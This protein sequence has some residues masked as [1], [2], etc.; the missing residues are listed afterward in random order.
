MMVAVAAA[1]FA[2]RWR[3]RTVLKR[4]PEKIGLNIQQSATGFT[5]SKSDQGHTLFKVQASKAVQFK[6]GGRTEL[7]DVEITVY[8][9]DSSRFDRIFGQDFVYE[10][11]SGN[12]SAE[13]EVRI[14][15][16]ANPEGVLNPD[17]SQPRELKNP[18]HLQTSGLV[19][20][21]KT[22]DAYTKEKIE[23][24][25]EN[26]RGS[27]MGASYT[28]KNSVLT[29]QSEINIALSGFASDL[30]PASITASHGTIEKDPALVSLEHPQL[31]YGAKLARAGDA[32]LFLRPNSKIDRVL[33]KGD[34]ILQ[35]TGE[36]PMSARANQME[37]F[38]SP[39]GAELRNAV[40]SGDVHIET[41]GNQAIRVD[42][43]QVNG[44]FA[45]GN[46]L[47]KIRAEKLVKMIQTHD[48]RSNPS[49]DAQDFELRASGM[50]FFLADGRRLQR[51]ETSGAAEAII[52]SKN[53]DAATE[54][55]LISA[56]KFRAQFDGSGQL[57][58]IHGAPD[59]RITSKSDKDKK[60]SADR[61][62][63]SD[64][65]DLI[66]EQSN[67]ISSISQSGHFVY[68]EGDRKVV[69]ER[70][71]YTPADR[72]IAL[73]GSPRMTDKG[74]SVV[75][76]GMQMDFAIGNAVAEG[77]VKTTY[78][79]LKPMQQGALLASSDPIHVTADTMTAT[80]SPS[81]ANYQ[82]NA[83]LW[84][85]TDVISAP[86]I[87]FDQDRRSVLARSPGIGQ[88]SISLLQAGKAS[89]PELVTIT[90][91]SFSYV[92]QERKAHLEGP[93]LVTQSNATIAADQMEIFLQPNGQASTSG[94]APGTGKVE[95]IVGQGNILITQTG[96]KATGD[97]LVYTASD[98]KFVLSGKSP[99]IFDATH[100]RITGVSL[101]LFGRDGRVLVEGSDKSPALTQSQVAR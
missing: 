84:Q 100:G 77:Q 85:G 78:T 70:A 69:A 41:A 56:G 8:G 94:T 80:R 39:E 96:R 31:R 97:Q 49:G 25:V 50:D 61:V 21:Q 55:T 58:T 12:I 32:V 81:K 35:S 16:E 86:S 71:T 33:A 36:Q 43:G 68:T 34:V 24:T 30:T 23:F 63:S 11:S 75:A 51:A 44:D 48:R 93:V 52:S 10:P 73:T 83:R 92:D 40:L 29:L 38:L 22:G 95:R 19:F 67:S 82:G 88:V 57:R 2:A 45:K 53:G 60:D 72:R 27:A 9:R 42:A 98:D 91:R 64:V 54:H 20:N 5:I 37:M 6:L 101:T 89:K 28:A 17:Q 26:A 59:A 7:H 62:S 3:V 1:Y 79:G 74:I 13:G 90:S 47:A 15:L 65:L 14:D 18:I 87:E 4:A 99:S 76:R 66:F 46:Q